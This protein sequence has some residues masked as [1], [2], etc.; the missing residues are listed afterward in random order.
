LKN[1]QSD[2]FKGQAAIILCA[3][4][5]ST[6]GLFIK[7]V[8]WHPALIAGSRSFLAAFLL[9]ALRKKQ[10]GSVKIIPLVFSGFWY[11]ATMILFVIA[12]KLT[13]SANAILLQYTAPVWT[14]LLAWFIL[15]E[16]PHWA[17]WVALGLVCLG[18]LLVFGSGLKGDSLLGDIIAL[19]SGIAFAAN[20]IAVRGYK[21]GDPLDVMISAHILT[22]LFSIPFFFIFPPELNVANILSI[23]F[24]GFFQIGAASAL[25]V[26]G[27]R[28]VRAAQAMLTATIEPVLN[29][30][31]VLLVTG[32]KPAPSVFAGG[33]IIIAAVLFSSLVSAGKPDKT[34]G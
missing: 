2:A 25:F 27:V 29:P 19:I 28:R 4:L 5:W 20:S 34:N 22:A 13:F 1:Q 3:I 21:G 8:D 7:L 16:K 12:N 14:C 15:K 10:Q 31:W 32:E 9:L 23:L 24:M 26:Y 30:V 6:S 11:A 33:A 17:H 18:M